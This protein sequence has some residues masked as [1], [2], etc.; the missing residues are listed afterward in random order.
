MT[1]L[2]YRAAR[3]GFDKPC[4]RKCNSA[5]TAQAVCGRHTHLQNI[6]AGQVAAVR[7]AQDLLEKLTCVDAHVNIKN[8]VK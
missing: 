8:Q 5:E 4:I 6:P 2:W 3:N 7:A 1:R